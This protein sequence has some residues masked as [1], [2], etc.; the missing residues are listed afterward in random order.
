MFEKLLNEMMLFRVSPES[1]DY[2]Q[3]SDLPDSVILIQESLVR[4][5]SSIIFRFVNCLYVFYIKS[6]KI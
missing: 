6:E 3:I 1:N 4:F 2:N 5:L